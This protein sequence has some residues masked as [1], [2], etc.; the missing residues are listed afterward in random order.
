MSNLNKKHLAFVDAYFLNGFNGK[1]AYLSVY[2]DVK[3]TAAEAAAS[4][5]LSTVKV[6]KEVA[7]R[8]AVTAAKFEIKKE[9]LMKDLLH[10][11]NKNLDAFPPSAIKAIEV[12]N[13]MNGFDAPTKIEHSGD[14]NI[15]LKIPGMDEEETEK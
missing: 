14:L 2:K 4:R 13:K 5:L 9:D 10:I 7:D 11:K 1:Q 12:L 8:Q 3:D 15:N 6:A